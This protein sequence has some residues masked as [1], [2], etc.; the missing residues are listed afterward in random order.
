M[1]FQIFQNSQ[2]CKFY[3]LKKASSMLH[4]HGI[5]F[6]IV[7]A[8]FA[9]QMVLQVVLPCGPVVTIW[10][11]VWPLTAVYSHMP[12]QIP[13]GRHRFSTYGANFGFELCTILQYVAPIRKAKGHLATKY[14][15]VNVL[16][17]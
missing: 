4:V 7:Y 3:F 15:D 5:N 17:V 16:H 9:S 6:I 13:C 12:R 14:T 1:L 10:T 2:I 11:L 8:V